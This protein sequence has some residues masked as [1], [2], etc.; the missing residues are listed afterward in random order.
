MKNFSVLSL[1]FLLLISLA[2]C[3]LDRWEGASNNE[4]NERARN[5]AYQENNQENRV[6]D[7][8][9]TRTGDHTQ[10]DAVN[11]AAEQLAALK[12]VERANVLV[13]NGNAYVAVV[14]EDEQNGEVSNGLKKRITDEVKAA[15]KDIKQVFV[16]SDPVFVKQMNDYG[17]KITE[18]Q[19]VTGLVDEFNK[20]VQNVFTTPNS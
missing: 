7:E 17:E 11:D 8:Y 18:G 6:T 2:G 13:T 16:S 12:E 20:M 10:L 9:T 14:L 15:D 4:N 3:N 19:P 5:M 1:F